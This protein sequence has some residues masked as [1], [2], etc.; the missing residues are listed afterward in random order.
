MIMIVAENVFVMIINSDCDACVC[1]PV[2]SVTV[3]IHRGFTLYYCDARGGLSTSING[4]NTLRYCIPTC[5]LASS[6]HCFISPWSTC[7]TTAIV[8][9]SP[10][11]PDSAAVS[12]S[13]IT[14]VTNTVTDV[15]AVSD[16]CS[17]TTVII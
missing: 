11:D 7:T 13:L 10:S 3:V 12:V 15:M 9:L 14:N 4:A 17:S 1:F 8:T 6:W 5:I 2:Y 16:S